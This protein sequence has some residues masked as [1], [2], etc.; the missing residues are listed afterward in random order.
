MDDWSKP[1][2][3]G[4]IGAQGT[5]AAVTRGRDTTHAMTT[6][7]GNG[8]AS[9]VRG[10][11]GQPSG[12]GLSESDWGKLKDLLGHSN[13]RSEDHLVGKY[14][15]STTWIIDMGAS[16]HMTGDLSNMFNVVDVSGCPIGL[17]DGTVS[18]VVKRGSIRLSNE[19][20]LHDLLYIP[21][22]A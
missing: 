10:S 6:S 3:I 19:L 8:A 20:I 4:R 21:Q 2:G 15:N 13:S 1:A 22:F 11:A 17:P 9:E 12:A 16:S 18:N 7:V 5:A 14:F